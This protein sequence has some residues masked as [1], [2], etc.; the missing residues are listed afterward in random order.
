[1]SETM[2]NNSLP[3][4]VK[5]ERGNGAGVEPR[6]TLNFY[7]PNPKGTGCALKLELHPA[8]YQ[9][10][11]SIMASF[12][13]QLTIGNPTGPNPTF[14]RFDWEAKVTVKLD[15]SDLAKILQVF[16]GETESLE[17]GRGII[18]S[19][20]AGLTKIQLNHM[21]DPHSGYAFEVY[22]TERSR[23]N[24]SHCYIFLKDWEALG[25]CRAIESSLGVICFG[26]PKVII[27]DTSDYK[28]RVRNLR[29]V[30]A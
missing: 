25:L 24:E 5:S 10:D 1:M 13:N 20:P 14:A 18:H 9:T 2:N 3:T 8:H 28:Q 29:N 22:R 23:G 27:R 21:I 19:S 6:P 12:A 15:F 16:R 11:G 26:I 30:A 17:E 7:H 4:G